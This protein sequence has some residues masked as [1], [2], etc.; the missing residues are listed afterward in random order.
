VLRG[1]KCPPSAVGK[2]LTDEGV[3][4]PRGTRFV[5]LMHTSLGADATYVGPVLARCTDPWAAADLARRIQLLTDNDGLGIRAHKDLSPQE[6][7]DRQARR[8]LND[9]YNDYK[10]QGYSLMWV[11]GVKLYCWRSGM[12]AWEPLTHPSA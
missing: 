2:R 8:E 5:P 4:V 1:L 12:D 9:V 3:Q 6:R 7:A 10:A 11:D